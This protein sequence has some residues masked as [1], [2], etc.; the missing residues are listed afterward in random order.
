MN[1][2]EITLD[3]LRGGHSV[4]IKGMT[5]RMNKGEITLDEL[6]GRHS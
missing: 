3:E 4:S 6:R 1:K 2:G 5:P